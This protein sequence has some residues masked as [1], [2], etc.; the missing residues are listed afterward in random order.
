MAGLS[1]Q[2]PDIPGPDAEL[3]VTGAVPGVLGAP[4]LSAERFKPG[5]RLPRGSRTP[6]EPMGG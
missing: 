5:T 2:L 1:S 6:W 3:V 4:P